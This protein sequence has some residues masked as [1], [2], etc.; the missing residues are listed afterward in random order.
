[1]DNEVVIKIQGMEY[2]FKLKSSSILYLEKKLGRN[3]FEAFQDPDFTV[4]VNVFFACANNE[5]KAKYNNEADLF[6]ALLESY[7]MA[8]LTDKYLAEIVQ[9][10][11]LVQKQQ[12]IPM[13]PSPEISAKTWNK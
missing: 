13:T 9:K 8:E 3:I 6:D 11:G 2:T 7:S 4:M 1:M 10:S 12:E 5:C